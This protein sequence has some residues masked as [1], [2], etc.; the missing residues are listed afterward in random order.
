MTHC[1]RVLFLMNRES[2]TPFFLAPPM[3]LP[4]YE[5]AP[6]DPSEEMVWD[7]EFFVVFVD[8]ITEQQKR[9]AEQSLMTACARAG[10]AAFMPPMQGTVDLWTRDHSDA[11]VED[12]TRVL[13]DD[14][15]H[16][17]RKVIV[18]DVSHAYSRFRWRLRR[19]GGG[20]D[21][22]RR[23]RDDELERLNRADAEVILSRRIKLVNL[24]EGAS[25]PVF[26][27]SS[28]P[29]FAIVINGEVISATSHITLPVGAETVVDAL[30]FT[31]KVAERFCGESPTEV[32]RGSDFDLLIFPPKE[33]PSILLQWGTLGGWEE[34]LHADAHEGD[35][36]RSE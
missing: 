35:D 9:Y 23:R 20:K 13:R 16:L 21:D 7:R 5:Y 27:S 19:E 14:L 34:V 10:A 11:V 29:T 24:S 18:R 33:D 4:A 26:Y 1:R 15:P 30:T 17:V 28:D 2:A 12:V 36:I 31:S 22:E 3:S 6:V 8:D 32:V 25:V